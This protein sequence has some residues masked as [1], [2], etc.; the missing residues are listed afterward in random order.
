MKSGSLD[1]RI[2]VQVGTESK[3]AEGD[4]VIAWA[5]AFKRWA[6]KFSG[7]VSESVGAGQ[8]VREGD[9]EWTLR[10]DAESLSITPELHRFIWEERVYEIVGVSEA[11]N[12]HDGLIFLTSS[13]PDGR[14][15]RGP[16]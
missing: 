4:V 2:M 10:W 5:D 13:R 8:V 15:P 7:P 11:S 12:R 6:R 3:D 9:T 16:L 1:R 14:G